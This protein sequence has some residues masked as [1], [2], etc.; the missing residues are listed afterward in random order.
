MS[1][2]TRIRLVISLLFMLVSGVSFAQTYSVSGTVLNKTTGDPVDFATVI[3][4]GTGQ[5]AVADAKGAFTINKVQPGKTVISVSCLGYV[6]DSKEIT[7]SRTIENYKVYLREDN[8]SLE[9]AVVTAQTNENSATTSR[10][11]DKTALDHVQMMNVSDLSSLLPGGATTNPN[12]TSDQTI[13]I[14]SGNTEAGNS[15]FGTA[16]EVDGVRLSS[17]ASF[18]GAK[19]VPTNSIATSNVESVEVITGVPSVE[20]GDMTSGVV[21]INSRK[22]K[23]P[24][25]ITASTSPKTKQVSVSKGFGLGTDKRGNSRGVLNTSVEYTNS[26]SKEMSPYTAYNRRQLSLTYSNLFNGGS[27]SEHPLRFSVGVTGNIGGLNSKSDPDLIANTYDICRDNSIRG[28]FNF[29]WLLSLPWITNLEWGA[30]VSYSDK[31]Q[32]SQTY[33]SSAVSKTVLHGT[34]MGYFIAQDYT[35]ETLPAQ[36]IDPGYWYNEMRVDDQPT[37]FKLNLKANWARNFGKVNSKLKIGADWTGDYNFGIGEYSNQM[38]NAPT[39]REY[40][41]CDKPVMHN[42]AVYAEE[43]L[44]IPVGKGRLNIIAGL[45]NDNTIIAGSEYGVT[46]SLS[47]RANLKY[48][49]IDP[50]GRSKEILRSLSFRASWGLAVKQPSYNVLYP[51]PTYYDMNVFTSTTTSSGKSTNAYLIIPRSIEYN[52][53][54]KWQKNMQSE[55]GTEINLAGNKISLAAFWSRTYNAYTTAIDYERLKYTYTSIGNLSSC[56]IPLDNQQYSIDR[57]TGV[58]TVSDKTGTLPSESLGNTVYNFFSPVTKPANMENPIDRYGIEWVVDFAKVQ[59]INTTIRFDGTW[60]GY[61]YLDTNMDAYCPTTGKSAGSNDPFKYVG[62]Y[63]GGNSTS[64][65]QETQTV[66]ANLTVTTHIPKVRMIISLK[67]ESCLLKYSRSLSDR[68]DGN[69][70]RAYVLTDRSNLLSTPDASI[71][72]GD[73]YVVVFPD[74]YTSYDDPTPKNYHEMLVWAK[75][76]DKNLYSDLVSLAYTTSYTYMFKKDY[77]SPYF[78]VNASITKEIGDIASI[79]FYVNNFLNNRSQLKSSKSGTYYSVTSYIP[80]FYYGLTLRLK[81]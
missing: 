51:T 49:A 21:K 1:Q 30:S 73:N 72:D 57:N 35:G 13:S 5:W 53:D 29:D 64:N 56:S 65:G 20:Y 25:T 8:L 78:S 62:W 45:R 16:I 37:S 59:P 46:S 11:I 66:K 76:N 69:G 24:W 80:T 43:N 38:E 10:T 9:S 28:N 31:L 39:F 74:Y 12:L 19:G 33:N 6:T 77:L 71:Y 55:I 52:P 50:K 22:G 36:L 79:S 48:T 40:R 2:K 42:A 47:P 17:N 27:L 75:D 34:E 61:K 81:F 15:S 68:L 7:I 60:Y 67:L 58:V 26:V 70:A 23:T 63:Y 3:L 44:M 41:Y 32:K 54:L 4:E 14:R 18:T